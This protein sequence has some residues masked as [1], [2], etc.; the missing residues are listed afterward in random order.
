MGVSGETR[1]VHRARERAARTVR[2]R[3]LMLFAVVLLVVV[4]IIANIQPLTHFQDASARLGKATAKVEGLEQQKAQLQNQLARLNETG[5]L[6]T[7]ARQQMTYVRPGED[8][9]IVTGSS[10]DAVDGTGAT[11]AA[12]TAGATPTFTS[13]GLGAGM[14]GAPA[15]TDGSGVPTTTGAAGKGGGRGA[16]PGSGQAATEKPGFFER[17]ITAI[18]GLF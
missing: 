10:G 16:G 17:A 9:Y 7:L 11:G 8:L 15:S 5:Y 1:V 14:V 2:L 13:Q 12:G 6:E 18:R 3:W 4:A